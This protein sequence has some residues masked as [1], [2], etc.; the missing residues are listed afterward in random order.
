[1]LGS[2]AVSS[3]FSRASA[4]ALDPDAASLLTEEDPSNDDGL[5]DAFV[6]SCISKIPR[7]PASAVSI[8][9]PPGFEVSA[10]PALEA[11]APAAPPQS[12]VSAPPAPEAQPP[13][14]RSH[15]QQPKK[16]NPRGTSVAPAS[17][18]EEAT[19]ED[20]HATQPESDETTLRLS[21]PLQS[22]ESIHDADGDGGVEE[23]LEES[24]IPKE[25]KKRRKGAKNQDVKGYGSEKSQLSLDEIHSR[26]S[27]GISR[28]SDGIKEAYP[29]FWERFGSGMADMGSRISD[30]VADSGLPGK[31]KKA[32]ENRIVRAIAAGLLLIII[33][34]MG[35]EVGQE[36]A[37]AQWE[38]VPLPSPPQPPSKPP[39]PPR[40]PPHSPPPPGTPPPP[41]TPPTPPPSPPP[42]SPP[43]PSMP[44]MPPDSS[45][46]IKLNARFARG[47]AS[48]DLSKVGVL[49]HQFDGN[50]NP[51]MAWERCPPICN[52]G[53]CPCATTRDRISASV[54]Y[55]SGPAIE[56]GSFIQLERLDVGGF[57]LYPDH[58]AAD[59]FCSYI[60]SAVRNSLDKQCSPL[61]K[62]A[63]CTPGCVDENEGNT[64]DNFWCDAETPETDAFCDGRPYAANQLEKMLRYH[65]SSGLEG[66]NQVVLDGESMALNLPGTIH[67]FFYP[68]SDFCPL[69]SECQNQVRR[70]HNDF[71]EF[72]K[73]S[74]AEVPLLRVVP[75][76]WD[77]PFQQAMMYSPAPPPPPP[78][79]SPPPHPPVARNG[80]F[81]ERVQQEQAALAALAALGGGGYATQPA[82]LAGLGGGGYAPQL[83]GL[84]GGGY[85]QQ[86]AGLG[87]GGFA[88]QQ[89]PGGGGFAY[90]QPA[91]RAPAVI[92][93][94]RGGFGT[95]IVGNTGPTD[96]AR[97]NGLQPMGQAVGG[98]Q[99]EP[100]F[101]PDE[102]AEA[103]LPGGAKAYQTHEAQIARDERNV[104]NSD[105][106]TKLMEAAAAR[107][108]A[109]M[110][111]MS[112][113]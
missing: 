46:L 110:A 79:L 50:E 75:T 107:A 92:P 3:F 13:T 83:A 108:A 102:E 90:Q 19:A 55:F 85:G 52:G 82:A 91:A 41:P 38:G 6:T 88:L 11:P 59:P 24:L 16:K 44:P 100:T 84:I 36:E 99:P 15:K 27:D 111:A 56:R 7:P 93:H 48:N 72:Y 81:S 68:E 71:L 104:E 65:R 98:W 26:I 86:L 8:T 87:G 9:M 57:V 66:A 14:G 80:L 60:S 67:A 21:S 12:D 94:P 64:I 5:D 4:L 30:S 23:A 47:V 63:N 39:L 34:Q 42:P 37:S 89:A 28:I 10:P 78:Q 69:Y 73:K 95:A 43:P 96:F 62:S 29:I 31:L 61:G 2:G 97:R 33:F 106:R 1:M 58:M 25:K 103:H 20:E 54:I 51:N 40:P 109:A 76:D 74:E 18:D 35:S 17:G 112:G 22:H 101:T 77:H 105:E 53:A 113:R 32:T 49:V 70:A 45:L